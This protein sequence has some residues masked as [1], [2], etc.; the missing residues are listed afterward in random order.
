MLASRSGIG[1]HAVFRRLLGVASGLVP[2][3][4]PE[5]ASP[6]VKMALSDDGPM[7]LRFVHVSDI[8]F[9]QEIGMA[10]QGHE[11][12]RRKLLAD[13]RRLRTDGT[14]AGPATGILLTGDA[15]QSGKEDQ[16]KLA[17]DWIEKLT[18]DVGCKPRAVQVIPGNH[19]VDVSRLDHTGKMMQTALLHGPL[20]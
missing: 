8:H 13:C 17:A 11:D 14:I 20:S 5:T 16:F 7:T 19:D 6:A 9:G 4:I 18:E 12:V 15:A 2:S 10:L 3:D 1:G